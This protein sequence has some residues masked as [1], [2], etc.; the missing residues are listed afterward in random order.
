[1]LLG[2]HTCYSFCVFA[3]LFFVASYVL[4]SSRSLPLRTHF[5]VFWCMQSCSSLLCLLVASCSPFPSSLQSSCP[6][7][8][9]LL[10]APP[11]PSG[12]C[13]PFAVALLEHAPEILFPT[14]AL[15][16]ALWHAHQ[17]SLL[18]GC[19][20]FFAACYHVLLFL[21]PL[22]ALCCVLGHALK[23]PVSTHALCHLFYTLRSLLAYCLLSFTVLLSYFW[24]AFCAPFLSL[25]VPML[26]FCL[27]RVG[28][29]AQAPTMHGALLCFGACTLALTRSV[30]TL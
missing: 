8:A 11:V 6:P 29:S 19:F 2:T 1:M 17:F 18:C 10:V 12:R 7:L 26:S 27:V 13:T 30:C 14:Q 21:A 16:Y 3:S 20:L 22:Q 23:F 25:P 5:V 9:A 15:C 24:L 28:G 4:M